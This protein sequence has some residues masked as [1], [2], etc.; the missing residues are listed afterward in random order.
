MGFL[1]EALRDLGVEAFGVDISDYAIGQVREDIRPYCRQGSVLDPFERRYDLVTCI[2]VAEH[3]DNRD[4]RRLVQNLCGYAD[5]VLFSSTPVDFAEETH[6]NVQS[7][8]HWVALF[9]AEGFLPDVEY[10]ASYISDWT[11]LFRNQPQ[12]DGISIPLLRAYERQRA[13]AWFENRVLRRERLR[14]EGKAEQLTIQRDELAAEL[15]AVT[16]STAYRMAVRART[17]AHRLL[18]PA[19]RRG[20][21]ASSLLRPLSGGRSN[22]A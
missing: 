1:V 6:L 8:D 22:Q 12:S 2:E 9:A 17:F 10:D 19:S 14:A 18:P 4:G 21:F 13:R 5:A 16:Q 3:L 7:T 15:A 20:R 11:I